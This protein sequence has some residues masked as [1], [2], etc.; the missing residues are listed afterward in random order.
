ML[1]LNEDTDAFVEIESNPTTT[2][3][4]TAPTEGT[5][6]VVNPDSIQYTPDADYTGMDTLTYEIC[7]ASAIC[8]TVEVIIMVLPVNDAPVAMD[9]V[10][11]TD[12]DIMV[13]IDVQNNEAIPKI[14][15]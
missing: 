4:L 8:D 13:V 14:L 2:T 12:E 5:A 7:D 10:A 15:L 9:D 3:I 11:T 1:V 6:T